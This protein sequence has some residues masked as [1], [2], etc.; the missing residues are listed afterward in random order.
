[1]VKGK[2]SHYRNRTG[3]GFTEYVEILDGIN[4]KEDVLLPLN[5]KP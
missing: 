5:L 2:I 1:M 3:M 4:T